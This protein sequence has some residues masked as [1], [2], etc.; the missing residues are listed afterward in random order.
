LAECTWGNGPLADAVWDR[1]PPL[2]QVPHF[3]PDVS[4]SI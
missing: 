2:K 1:D 3:K 4:V